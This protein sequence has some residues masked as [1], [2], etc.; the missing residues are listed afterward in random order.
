MAAAVCLASLIASLLVIIVWL[1][2][3]LLTQTA[4]FIVRVLRNFYAGIAVLLTVSF[5]TSKVEPVG[6]FLI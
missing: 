2:K 5:I 4:L 1:V 6:I 3:L